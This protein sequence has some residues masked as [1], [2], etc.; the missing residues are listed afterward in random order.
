M[1]VKGDFSLKKDLMRTLFDQ[2]KTRAVTW[3]LTLRHDS[4]LGPVNPDSITGIY[5]SDPE[6]YNVFTRLFDPVIEEYHSG[7]RDNDVHSDLD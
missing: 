7:F 3:D 4:R 6:T 1:F 2:L 5:A